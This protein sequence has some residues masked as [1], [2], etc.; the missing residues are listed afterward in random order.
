LWLHPFRAPAQLL[1][2]WFPLPPLIG[3]FYG[4]FTL[5][6][7]H[8]CTAISSVVLWGSVPTLWL[9]DA[10]GIKTVVGEATVFQKDVEAVSI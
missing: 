4:K 6:A 8:G 5:Y 10:E 2:R 3:S 1:G 7:K 9:A